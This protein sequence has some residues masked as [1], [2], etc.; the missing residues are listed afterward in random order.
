MGNW[1][2][3]RN[4]LL[5]FLFISIILILI[6]VS[7]G[8]RKL[9]AIIK[10][11]DLNT[12]KILHEIE[13]TNKMASIGRLAAGVSH[14]IN[15]PLSI[16]NE[17]AGMIEDFLSTETNIPY[18]DKLL[19]NVKAIQ[20]SIERCTRITHQLLG[21]AKRM[22]TKI[23]D[24]YIN[25]ILKEVI[26]FIV[27]E[28]VM[29]NIN[30]ILDDTELDLKIKS[31]RG[32]LQQVFINIINNAIEAVKTGGIINIKY[33]SLDENFVIIKIQDNGKGISEKDLN[34]IF[35]PFYST[36]KEYGT[37]LGLSITYG[38]IKKLGGNIQVESVINEGTTFL[39]TLP[40][41]YSEM[42]KSYE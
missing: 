1:L 18:K 8:S 36:K 38:I 41:E 27:K 32:L 35:E 20:R 13:Y 5:L 9:I 37:G 22:D 40:Y 19:R 28:D 33:Q 14:E 30:I 34:H 10:E 11:S 24:I 3:T 2:K 31:D 15:N 21:F 17:N 12:A 42:E 26:R 7:W 29:E 6:A 39:I 16:I 4:Q 25:D 23:E